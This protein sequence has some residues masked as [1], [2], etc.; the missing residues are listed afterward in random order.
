MKLRFRKSG[1]FAPIFQGCQFDTD[2]NPSGADN[3][4]LL[5]LVESSG[6]ISETGKQN[7]LAR[8]V[9]LFTFEIEMSGRRNRVTFDQLS[10]PA[11]VQPLLDFLME[12]A[13]N[14]LP[15]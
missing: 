14:M 15:E 3:A 9:F 6:I 1:G 10:V 8:D 11:K 13:K 5:E 4:R 2:A 7:P 12:R